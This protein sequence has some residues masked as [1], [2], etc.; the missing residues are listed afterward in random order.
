MIISAWEGCWS[1]EVVGCSRNQM[2]RRTTTEEIC[3]PQCKTNSITSVIDTRD[4]PGKRAR[5]RRHL[6]HQCQGRFTTYEVMAEEYEKLR[7]ISI[8]VSKFDSVIAS[9]R[10]IKAQL[11][12]ANGHHQ[13]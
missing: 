1:F 4:V 9:L 11:G 8:D 13:D 3:C 10:A 5:R 12:A 6:C 2:K 7:T